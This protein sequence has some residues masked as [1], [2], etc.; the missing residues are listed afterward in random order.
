MVSNKEIVNLI[1]ANVSGSFYPLSFSRNSPDASSTVTASPAG[2]GTTGGIGRVSVQVITRDIHP[3]NAE[4][5]SLLVRSFLHDRTDFFI[6]E[7]VQVVHVQANDILPFFIGTDE[8]GRY[9]FS[10][11]YNFILGV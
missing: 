7:N 1:K 8:N 9:L 2:S 10:L 5:Q 4:K 6:A 3:D 11:N